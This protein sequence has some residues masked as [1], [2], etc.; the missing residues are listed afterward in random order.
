MYFHMFTVAEVTTWVVMAEI[1]TFD[2]GGTKFGSVV[3]KKLQSLK[4]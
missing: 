3:M 4:Y 2:C 1:S